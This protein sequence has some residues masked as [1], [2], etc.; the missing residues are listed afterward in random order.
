MDFLNQIIVLVLF[1]PF[2]NK[3]K[4]DCL[5]KGHTMLE[6][7]KKT[8]FNIGSGDIIINYNFLKNGGIINSTFQ[9]FDVPNDYNNIFTKEN[10]YFEIQ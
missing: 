9:S 10:G 5:N 4:Y 7:N 2:K 6:V 8:L 3:E 1:F